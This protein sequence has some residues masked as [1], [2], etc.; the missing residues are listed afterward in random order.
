MNNLN[1][2]QEPVANSNAYNLALEAGTCLIRQI[3]KNPNGKNKY[4][5]QFEQKVD[6]DRPLPENGIDELS[7]YANGLENIESKPQKAIMSFAPFVLEKVGMLV[8]G[9]INGGEPVHASALFPHL[10]EVDFNIQVVEDTT[11]DYTTQSVK[12]NP[13]TNEV[14]LYNGNPIYS[15]VKLVTGEPKHSLIAHTSTVSKMEYNASLIAI[16]GDEVP[17]DAEKVF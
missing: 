13:Q 11:P 8:E 14:L 16:E 12:I 1:V 10:K 17:A 3:F 5:V 2:S 7:L 15:H 4:T 6:L 9:Y